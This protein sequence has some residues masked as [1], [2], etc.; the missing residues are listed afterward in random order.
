MTFG[1]VYH[2]KACDLVES[3]RVR[4][5]TRT[6]GPNGAISVFPCKT[7]NVSYKIIIVIFAPLRL[8]YSK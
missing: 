6:N 3:L 8:F 4:T 1:N 2:N 7:I 5:T